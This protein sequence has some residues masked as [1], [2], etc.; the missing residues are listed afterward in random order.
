M[1]RAVLTLV[2][3]AVLH[4]LLLLPGN[5]CNTCRRAH[6][7]RTTVHAS[8]SSDTV[9]EQKKALLSA[10]AQ[11]GPDRTD[12][13]LTA[14]AELEANDLVTAPV[15]GRWSLVF[16]TMSSTAATPLE[17]AVGNL[18]WENLPRRASNAIYKTLFRFLPALAGGQ[19]MRSSGESTGLRFR[20]INSQ[21]V[22][23]AAGL[24]DN[25]VDVR[26]GDAP[27]VRIRV[28]GTAEPLITDGP[29]QDRDLKVTFTDTSIGPLPPATFPPTLKIPLPRPVG[30]LRTTFCDDEI[31]LSRG[32]RGGLFV[33][34]RLRSEE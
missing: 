13:I 22:D 23:V 30:A 5:T 3:P 1:M 26:V 9:R 24:V 20:A 18:D 17:G 4:G 14:A 21:V 25:T 15:S 33:L 6:T 8:V 2:L 29:D 27:A 31:R 11:R 16:S 10:V 28:R 32:G 19:E 34:K 7:Q 12:A